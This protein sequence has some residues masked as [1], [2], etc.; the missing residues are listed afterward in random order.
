MKMEFCTV[1]IQYLKYRTLL[2]LVFPDIFNLL[3]FLYNLQQTRSPFQNDYDTNNDIYSN[4]STNTNIHTNVVSDAN[5]S[6]FPHCQ[7]THPHKA[8]YGAEVLPN[9]DD[10]S[11]CLGGFDSEYMECEDVD[12]WEL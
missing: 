8:Y 2:H 11:V 4:T 5:A 9:D 10:V 12:C 6:L 3:S 1:P 7:D